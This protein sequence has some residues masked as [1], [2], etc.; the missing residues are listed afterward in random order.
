MVYRSIQKDLWNYAQPTATKRGCLDDRTR[1]V[2]T[3]SNN[4]FHW[5]E[6]EYI[7][8]AVSKKAPPNKSLYP[9]VAP[10]WMSRTHR[11]AFWKMFETNS[12]ASCL[13][14]PLHFRWTVRWMNWLYKQRIRRNWRQCTSDGVRSSDF[15]S[16]GHTF[17]SSAWEIGVLLSLLS[18][19]LLLNNW[20]SVLTAQEGVAKSS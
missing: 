20:V 3:W 8:T 13:S 10:M 14:S 18:L 9:S 17:Y 5:E 16:F 19:F 12:V 6:S 7:S 11:L 4:W 15:F 2:F 1:D